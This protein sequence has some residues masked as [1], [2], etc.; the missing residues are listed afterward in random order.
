MRYNEH[1]FTLTPWN[2]FLEKEGIRSKWNPLSEYK[3]FQVSV[4]DIDEDL[5]LN[6]MLCVYHKASPFVR[7]YESARERKM[8]TLDFFGVEKHD[9]NYKSGIQD[10]L[11]GKN[12]IANSYIHRFCTLQND[13]LFSMLQINMMAYD[14][15][16]HKM[17]GDI[18]KE[19]DTEKVAIITEKTSAELEK[20]LK[21]IQEQKK[22]FYQKDIEI[23]DTQDQEFLSYARVP[24]YPE[25]IAHGHVSI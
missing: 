1:D 15:L 14:K 2:P 9:G 5:F 13:Q 19:D 24:G 23:I 20:L 18:D 11:D 22:Q 16:M 25:L 12:R 3:E 17:I 4:P 21:R 7:D 6:Y 10:I 8:R